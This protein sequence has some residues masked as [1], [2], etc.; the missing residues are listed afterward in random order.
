MFTVPWK[1]SG[2]P[3]TQSIWFSSE[4]KYVSGNTPYTIIISKPPHYTWLARKTPHSILRMW[5]IWSETDE[6]NNLVTSETWGQKR[7]W[8][9][10]TYIQTYTVTGRQCK[11]NGVKLKKES[12]TEDSVYMTASPRATTDTHTHAFERGGIIGNITTLGDHLPTQE[13]FRNKHSIHSR[14]IHRPAEHTFTAATLLDNRHCRRNC[15]V[16]VLSFS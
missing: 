6:K 16:Y 1:N 4:D 13:H 12:S 7:I 11:I 10:L 15:F 2:R 5:D 9:T 3:S 14:N 8:Y